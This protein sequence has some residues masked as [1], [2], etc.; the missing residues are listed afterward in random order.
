MN[1]D[2]QLNVSKELQ[3]QKRQVYNFNT[4]RKLSTSS[5]SLHYM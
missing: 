4:V 5:R 3:R 1:T 2:A